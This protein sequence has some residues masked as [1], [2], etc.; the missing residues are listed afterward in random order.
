MTVT[1]NFYDIYKD[2]V[3]D[4]GKAYID[5]NAIYQEPVI[6]KSESMKTTAPGLT[7]IPLTLASQATEIV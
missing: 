2:Q 1:W 5:S 6:V 3:H 7:S 4:L